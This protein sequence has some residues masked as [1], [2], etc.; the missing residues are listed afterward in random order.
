M[1]K[2]LGHY[3]DKESSAVSKRWCLLSTVCW[4]VR[5]DGALVFK[6]TNSQKVFNMRSGPHTHTHTQFL[7]SC[8]THK[9]T[10]SLSLKHMHT[11]ASQKQLTFQQA[12]ADRLQVGRA[13][14]L[15]P[16]HPLNPQCTALVLILKFLHFKSNTHTQT[17]NTCLYRTGTVI[18]PSSTAA[19]LFLMA[20]SP[21][22]SLFVSSTQWVSLF[23]LRLW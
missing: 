12:T 4:R 2:R 20:A 3:Y 18:N 10:Y 9:R 7:P 23:C 22:P 1:S 8:W 14:P 13:Q 19:Y 5:S 11:R 17:G 16:I 21:S 6:K 15:Y